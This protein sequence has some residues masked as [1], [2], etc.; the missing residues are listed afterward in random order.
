MKYE[1]TNGDQQ[2]QS[3]W[4]EGFS[5]LLSVPS[6]AVPEIVTV[7]FVAPPLPP[8]HTDLA[9]TTWTY[10]QTT[11]STIVRNDAPGF[12]S[13]QQSLE[14]LAASMG[15]PYSSPKFYMESAVHELGHALY[16][17]LPEEHRVKIAQLFGAQ[18]DEISELQPPGSSWEDRI[19]EGIAETFKEA[20][21]PRAYRVFANR[22]HRKIPY[23]KYPEFRAL[24][25]EG[26]E[27]VT[28]SPG[29]DINIF[30]QGGFNSGAFFDPRKGLYSGIDPHGLARFKSL[31]VMKFD[32]LSG[33][34]EIPGGYVFN[35]VW[36]LPAAIF[37]LLSITSIQTSMHLIFEVT[38]GISSTYY[39]ARWGLDITRTEDE[40]G[41]SWIVG[42]GPTEFGAEIVN[43]PG[44]S[45][46]NPP[47]SLTD[48]ITT[49]WKPEEK[50]KMEFRC[51]VELFLNEGSGPII[52]ESA[53]QAAFVEPFRLT[54][55]DFRYIE[56]GGGTG[57]PITLPSGLIVPAGAAG[58]SLP[59][60]RPVVG[61]IAGL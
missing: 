46:A 52:E 27:K 38:E 20:F 15:I 42:I 11:A 10:G 37:E 53:I 4:Q 44:L 19:A 14:A 28:T 49:P 40:E 25:R 6:S 54:I 18:G 12:G 8:G 47:F 58:G 45:G 34:P 22:T 17:S 57:G 50:K 3:L 35:L 43:P 7:D 31:A 13:Q 2:Q 33:T 39:L 26:M 36:A 16:A 29:V 23:S 32:E 59:H 51:E 21:L 1:F 61:S 48:T 41:D 60:Q 24:W 30:E 9:L 5:H 56:G 55:P